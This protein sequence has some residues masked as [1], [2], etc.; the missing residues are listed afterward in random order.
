MV[1]CWNRLPDV[2]PLIPLSTAIRRALF[3]SNF[4]TQVRHHRKK[5]SAVRDRDLPR[6]SRK[7]EGMSALGARTIF[8]LSLRKCQPERSG[9]YFRLTPAA[10]E[11]RIRSAG[12][13]A[14]GAM[15][16][17]LRGVP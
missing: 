9:K 3:P 2:P 11:G 1:A 8:R 7:I 10:R 15:G 6:K 16:P 4:Q 17:F 5:T 14:S 12:R 13:R